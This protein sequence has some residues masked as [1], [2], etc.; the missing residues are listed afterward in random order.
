MNKYSFLLIITIFFTASQ[1]IAQIHTFNSKEP[2]TIIKEI[3]REN[4]QLYNLIITLPPDYHPKKEYKI[5][6][7]LDAWWLKD[8]VMG[9]Y[10]IKSLA[11]K[12]ISNNLE[13]VILVGISSVGDERA[14]NRQRNMDFT[15]SKFNSKFKLKFGEE[16]LNETTSGGAEEFLQFFKDQIITP[17]E[18]EY[19][20]DSTTRGLMGHS[21]G[22]LLGLY[23]YLE[24]SKL[25]VNYLLISPAVWWNQSEIFK[26]KG[27]IVNKR[28]S[29]I[30][31]AVGTSESEILKSPL[32]KLVEKIKS[33]KNGKLRMTYKQY[34]NADHHS[35]LPQAIYDGIEYIYTK[36]K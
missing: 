11:S 23:T 2:T 3:K 32:V 19:T 15:P 29:S 27:T 1:S 5:L 16:E 22:G 31:I 4:G 24:H 36:T 35:V 17:I 33:E 20:I 7:Y 28:E 12:T 30:F 13:E 14:W 18:N 25:F 9:C 21:F 6:Y 8:L 34:D 26:D 10:R